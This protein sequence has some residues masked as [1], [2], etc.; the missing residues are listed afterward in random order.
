[1][2]TT[3]TKVLKVNEIEHKIREVDSTMAME[4][5]PLTDDDKEAMRSVLR[6]EISYS[7]MKTRIMNEYKPQR[8]VNERA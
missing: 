4:G 6:G 1:M 3:R 2:K 8:V 7:D 5:M